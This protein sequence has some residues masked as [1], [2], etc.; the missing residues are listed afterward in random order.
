M[1]RSLFG[2]VCLAAVALFALGGNDAVSADKDKGPDVP[3]RKGRSEKIQLFTGKEGEGWEGYDDL[4]SVKEG[5]IVA[6]TK[7]PLKFSTYLLTKKN[8]TDFRLVFASKLVESEMHSGV[9]FWGEVRPSV[10]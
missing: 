7:V 1:R 4:W 10:S 6:K 8:Y 5:A 2:A 9:A 3:P